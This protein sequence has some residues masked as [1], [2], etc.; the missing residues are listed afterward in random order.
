MRYVYVD[1][2]EGNP[3]NPSHPPKAVKFGEQTTDEMGFAFL[4]VALPDRADVP[5]FRRTMQ[6]SRIE[7]IL[8]DGDDLDSLGPRQAA[9]LR[10]AIAAFD[11]NGNGKLEA[12]EL[13]ALMKFLQG[14]VR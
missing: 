8:R 12:D 4:Q 1:N 2:S 6:L 9:N 7:E 11:R 14:T 3:H 5:G 13:Q 10:R